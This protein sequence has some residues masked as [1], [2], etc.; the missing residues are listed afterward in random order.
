MER[1]GDSPLRRQI[2]V[3]VGNGGAR[4]LGAGPADHRQFHRLAHEAGIDHLPD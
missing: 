4:H 2:G 1:A 3:Q